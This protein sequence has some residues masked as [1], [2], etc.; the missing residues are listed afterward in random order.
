MAQFTIQVVSDS[1][2]ETGEYV[3]HALMKQFPDVAYRT[4]RHSYVLS[5]AQVNRALRRLEKGDIVISTMVI[6][7][8]RNYLKERCREM[9]IFYHDVLENPILKLEE[10]F[11]ESS[12]QDPGAIR[13]LDREY[14][15]KIEAIEFTVKY[16]DGK[17]PRGILSADIV[18]IGVSRTS[19]TPTSIYL[20]NKGY[21][22]CNIPLVPEVAPPKELFEADRRRIIGLIINPVKL[23]EIRRKRLENLG[24]DFRA[25]Y[26]NKER[27]KQELLYAMEVFDK[28]K[29]S[30]IDVTSSTIE[31][32]ASEIVAIY[33]KNFDLH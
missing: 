23:N 8:L 28:V 15:N 5:Q 26:A 7:K 20:A 11:N 31:G 29:C 18:L 17:D 30:V 14:F 1:V 10:Y 3:V 19:K 32:T 25:D 6:K 22:V 4:Q 9:G 33:N 24:L 27:I 2:G 12:V 21:K 16:D 13:R